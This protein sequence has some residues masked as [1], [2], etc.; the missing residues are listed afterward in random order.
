ML[1][2]PGVSISTGVVDLTA[3]RK[4]IRSERKLLLHYQ[5]RNET[6]SER[7]IWPFALGFFDHVRMI[8]AWCEMRQGFR[9]FRTDRIARLVSTD[10]RYLRRRQVLLKEWRQEEGIPPSL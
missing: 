3:I 1:V 7:M 5:D 9:H 6:D 4:A 10:M 2:G 8:V